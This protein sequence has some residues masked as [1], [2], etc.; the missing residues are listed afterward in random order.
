MSEGI[1][2]P[3]SS[4]ETHWKQHP[5]SVGNDFDSTVLQFCILVLLKFALFDASVIVSIL[6]KWGYIQPFYFYIKY[7]HCK[8][9]KIETT[10]NCKYCTCEVRRYLSKR[11][12]DVISKDICY[13]IKW[14]WFVEKFEYWVQFALN[15]CT[16]NQ[17]HCRYMNMWTIPSST[18]CSGFLPSSSF[19]LKGA[20]ILGP[21]ADQ[22]NYF[23]DARSKKSL[24]MIKI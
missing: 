8:P 7:W 11:C 17:N 16:Q 19:V 18:T 9:T 20:A 21:S 15:L 4:R 13:V 22:V 23:R 3:D 10:V 14:S 5:A 6:S 1:L 12:W 24:K 2:L